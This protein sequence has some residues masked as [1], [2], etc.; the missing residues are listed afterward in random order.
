M[1]DD[2]NNKAILQHA[3]T[4][5]EGLDLLLNY[6][7]SVGNPF[8]YAHM[9]SALRINRPDF[10]VRAAN[11]AKIC[12]EKF[13]HGM[14]FGNEA[15]YLI[16]KISSGAGRTPK[17]KIISVYSPTPKISDFPFEV[18]APRPNSVDIHFYPPI[19]QEF[20]PQDFPKTFPATAAA[21]KGLYREIAKRVDAWAI[22]EQEYLRISWAQIEKMIQFSTL[23]GRRP[24]RS[25]DLFFVIHS[26]NS[27]LTDVS[28][29]VEPL[30]APIHPKIRKV[31]RNQNLNTEIMEIFMVQNGIVFGLRGKYGLRG[32]NFHLYRG[33]LSTIPTF[34]EFQEVCNQ[35]LRKLGS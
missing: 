24:Y 15:A 29:S 12:R 17:G 6:H 2:L 34:P 16:P 28:L 31:I 3:R 10:R 21:E 22:L 9:M 4:W 11:V 1:W 14:N 18:D 5:T 19:T 13:F 8:T 32:R 30:G 20:R 33:T 35:R 26:A 23:I 27:F 7:C 25:R